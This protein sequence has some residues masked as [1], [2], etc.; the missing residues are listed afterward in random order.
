[1]EDVKKI[2]LDVNEELDN[3]PKFV[4]LTATFTALVFIATAVFSLGITSGGYFNFGE[5]M[6]YL[7]S[8]VGGPFV[9]MIAGGF[10]SSLAD[11]I[12]GYGIFAPGT[13][14]IKGL[15]G[16]I[17]GYIFLKIKN[18]KLS[19]L[20]IVF[21][22]FGFLIVSFAIILTT[23]PLFDVFFKFDFSKL[24]LILNNIG[25]N[26]FSIGITI[27]IPNLSGFEK[28]I[29]SYEFT[30]MLLILFTLIFT[31]S[32]FYLNYKYAEKS[33]MIVSCALGGLVIIFGYFIYE[34]INIKF[35]EY[36]IGLG[37]S[38]GQALSEVPVNISQVIIGIAIA[39]P[40]L[41]YLIKIGIFEDEV[42]N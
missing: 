9:G 12:L 38:V 3:T 26:T 10:G 31:I 16:F 25:S 36:S 21:Y 7:A 37:W 41:M 30:G 42:E 8:L 19:Q 32:I 23:P 4:A 24:N 5:S 28:I 35:G 29:L 39:V 11:M 27:F 6:I 33:K 22:V 15:E 40:T 13:F 18:L 34:L 20:K 1:M 17:V 2:N 14:V